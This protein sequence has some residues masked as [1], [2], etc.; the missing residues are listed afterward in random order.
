VK[1]LIIATNNPGKVDEFRELLDGCG[2]QIVAPSDVGL[3]LDVDETGTTYAENAAIKAQAFARATDLAALADDSGLEV[4]ALEGQPG[5][6]HH[7][8]GWDGTNQDERIAILVEAL[9]D[10][11]EPQRTARFRSVI[12]LAHDGQVEQTEGT[13]EG[14]IIGKAFGDGGFGYDP[15]FFIPERGST[16]AQLTTAEKNEVS[17]RAVAAR[18]M[19]SLLQSLAEASSTP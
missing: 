12:A 13:C 3:S 15:V 16:M 19:R 17:H 18:K 7:L 4:D 5:A 9:K 10:V 14:V 2:W 6:L 8:N 1:Q 11:A